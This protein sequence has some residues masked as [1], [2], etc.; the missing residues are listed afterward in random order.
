MCVHPQGFCPGAS[1]TPYHANVK[2]GRFDVD[3]FR[4]FDL[5]LNG[6][7]NLEVG[8]MGRRMG[9]GV[10]VEGCAWEG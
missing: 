6:L 3:F 7:D 10:C 5:V 8:G 4:R 1:I 9:H 2:E